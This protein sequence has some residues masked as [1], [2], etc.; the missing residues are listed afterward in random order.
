MPPSPTKIQR[1]V[2]FKVIVPIRLDKENNNSNSIQNERLF[3]KQRSEAE[4]FSRSND[5]YQHGTTNRHY[6]TKDAGH[7][8]ESEIKNNLNHQLKN[9]DLRFKIKNSLTLD[10]IVC[11]SESVVDSLKN[12]TY[13][14]VVYNR[15]HVLSEVSLYINRFHWAY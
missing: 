1:P 10:Q 2:S 14:Q 6:A 15:D 13:G 8:K 11:C 4:H 9:I 5:K 12:S 3:D 7:C